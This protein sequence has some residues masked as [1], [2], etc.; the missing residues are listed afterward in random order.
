MKVMKEKVIKEEEGEEG[1][2]REQV[3]QVEKEQLNMSN[4]VDMFLSFVKTYNPIQKI[5]PKLMSVITK[6]LRLHSKSITAREFQGFCEVTI[7][8]A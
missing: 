2:E 3:K 5:D 7:I 8:V 6:K 4:S 1:N